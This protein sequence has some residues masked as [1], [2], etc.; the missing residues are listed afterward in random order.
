MHKFRVL[1]FSFDI[2]A[3]KLITNRLSWIGFEAY[4]F[5]TFKKFWFCFYDFQP[6]LIIID[7]SFINRYIFGFVKNL[8]QVS[9]VPILLLTDN[10]LNFHQLYFFD[11]IHILSKPF[12]LNTLDL[13][14]SLILNKKSSYLY[15]FK[16]KSNTHL[17]IY[18][19]KKILRFD[20][21]F[22]FLTKTEIKII[23]LILSQKNQNYSKSM[24]LQ[25]IWGYNDFWSLKSNLLEMHFSK[26]KKKLTTFL[27]NSKFLT[28]KKNN[29]LFYF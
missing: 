25:H 26:I 12:S 21:S 6:D 27:K 24:F 1:V 9:S 16:F 14:V 18:L 19:N 10:Y 3:S 2:R 11:V 20:K 8:N 5:N 28:K 7:D 17:S 29:F 22:V 4:S 15:S 23:S 13:K